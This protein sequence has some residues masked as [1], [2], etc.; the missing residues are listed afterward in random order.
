MKYAYAAAVAAVTVASVMCAPSAQAGHGIRA[1]LPCPYGN[2]GGV[3]P[4]LWSA[5]TGSSPYNP[6]AP[7]AFTAALVSGSDITTDSGVGGGLDITGATQYDWYA[8]AIPSVASCSDSS[9][10]PA[11]PIEQVIDYK[12]AS[13]G[14]LGLAAG[15]TEV[16]FNYDPSLASTAGVASFTMGGVTFTSSGPL[17]P[18]TTD[19]SFLFS[20]SGALLGA[21]TTDS[22]GNTVLTAGVPTGWTSSSGGGGGTTTAPEIDPSYALSGFVLLVGGLAVIRGGRRTLTTA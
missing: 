2:A 7:T 3:N 20:A 10:S 17:L 9:S 19:N 16:Q 14:S 8:A 1:D 21:L 22:E 15:D 4:S 12:L 5:T 6:G 18:T 13:G 11:N